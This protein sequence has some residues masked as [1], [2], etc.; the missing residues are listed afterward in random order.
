MLTKHEYNVVAG[1]GIGVVLPI[2]IFLILL[3]LYI[4]EGDNLVK[5]TRFIDRR[6]QS[7]VAQ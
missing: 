1:V 4:V 3:V 2:F 6:Q 7:L 5:P